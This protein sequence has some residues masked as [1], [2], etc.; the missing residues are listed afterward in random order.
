[1]RALIFFVAVAL[2]TCSENVTPPVMV[3]QLKTLTTETGREIEYR[4]LKPIDCNDCPL[5]FFSHGAYAAYDRYDSLLLPIARAGY[6]VV[7]PNHTDSEEHPARSQY[8]LAE[9]L[10]NRLED[11]DVIIGHYGADDH[12][13]TGHSF[14]AMIAQ[15]TAGAQLSGD[16]SRYSVTSSVRPKAVIAISP[17]G[18]IPNYMEV[19]GWSKVSVPSLIVTGTNDIVPKMTENWEDHLTSFNVSPPGS[20][21]LVYSDMDHYMNGAYGRESD[22]N[23]VER[24]KAMKHLVTGIDTFIRDP[25]AMMQL[26]S[27]MVE[28]RV[29]E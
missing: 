7:A 23:T 25:E 20:Y 24:Q 15:I 6:H 11:Y 26:K 18:P 21:G 3:D 1:M 29:K 13:S 10:P 27:D 28:I 8:T 19:S 22:S 2:A 5:L 9:S 14:G 12:Y 17:P 4:S 16:A